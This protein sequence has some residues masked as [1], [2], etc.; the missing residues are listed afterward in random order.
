MIDAQQE[1]EIRR[2]FCAE[3]WKVGT[4]EHTSFSRDRHLEVRFGRERGCHASP[5]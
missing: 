2:L 1:A 5:G 4:I 3:Q